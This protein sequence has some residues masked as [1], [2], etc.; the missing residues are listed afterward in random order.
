MLGRVY[1]TSNYGFQNIFLY[2]PKI[3]ILEVRKD[4][5]N[6]YVLRWK[7]KGAFN[8]ELK[9]LHIAFLNSIKLSKYRIGIFDKYHLTVERNS[10]L[11]KIVNVYIV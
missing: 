11:R 10:C 7:S 5:G 4:K 2:Q 3:D 1:F 8:S 9:S 6:D